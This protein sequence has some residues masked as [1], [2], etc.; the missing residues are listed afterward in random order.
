[1]ETRSPDRTAILIVRLWI[2]APFPDG[3]RAR[4]VQT[5]DSRSREQTASMAGS[6]EDVY[7]AVRSWVEECVETDEPA[8][9]RR[10]PSRHPSGDAAVTPRRDGVTDLSDFRRRE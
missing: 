6:P 8:E 9:I 10:H 5:P 4:I 3:F 7:A 2:E 1:M